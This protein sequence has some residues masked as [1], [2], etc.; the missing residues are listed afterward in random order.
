[1][2]HAPVKTAEAVGPMATEEEVVEV[3]DLVV[4]A[5][6]QGEEDSEDIKLSGRCL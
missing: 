5:V 2:P 6:D 4:A 3:V 1:M